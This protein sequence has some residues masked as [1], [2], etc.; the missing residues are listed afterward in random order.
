MN[1]TTKSCL[2]YAS[3]MERIYGEKEMISGKANP[4]MHALYTFDP[5]HKGHLGIS[6][7]LKECVI[8]YHASD[9]QVWKMKITD[10][11]S[12]K[13]IVGGATYYLNSVGKIVMFVGS[14]TLFE[15]TC[16]HWNRLFTKSVLQ[17]ILE[18]TDYRG[19]DIV[20]GR[21]FGPS[22][23]MYRRSSNYLNAF[24]IF[25]AFWEADGSRRA[26]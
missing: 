8:S 1:K 3:V 7:L 11:G 4:E 14:R 16:T 19:V 12:S 13:R 20:L 24:I 26:L 15:K 5:L 2:Q 25:H 23:R 9:E 22:N 18:G 21:A 17:G 6:N 10:L